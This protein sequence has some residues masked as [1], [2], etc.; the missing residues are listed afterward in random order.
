MLALLAP[1]Q[2]E[3]RV[4]NRLPLLAARDAAVDE[5]VARGLRWLRDQQNRN[6]FW[7]GL[8]GARSRDPYRPSASLDAQIAAGQGHLGVTAL[9]GMAFLA[10]GHLPDRGEHG[11]VV[12]RATNAVLSCIAENGVLTSSG[13]RMYSHAF[14]TLFLAEVYGNESS[15]ELK[16]GL[17]R[18]TNIIVDTQ[19][20]YG[21]WRYQAFSRE[22]DLSVTV[23]QL[24]ALRAARNIGIGIPKQTID[25]AVNYVVEHQIPSGAHQGR[26]YY[27]IHG[28]RRNRKSDHYSI[29]AAAATSL[30]SAGIYE[31]RLLDDVIDFLS[32]EMEHV[33][34]SEPHHYHF[35]YGNYYASQVFYHADGLLRKGCFQRYYDTMRRHL[36]ADQLPDGNWH[37]PHEEGPGDAFA[38]AIACIILQIPKQYLPI[39]QR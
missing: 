33:M 6:G 21:G 16:V 12:K 24:Q 29:Q 18:A 27:N 31:K 37:N 1:A 9:C 35:W 15:E 23:C 20:N 11:H 4:D 25:R 17:E 39:F 28:R 30:L 19:N 38:T 5:S 13:T 8:V 32:D 26:Y 34:R 2:E 36:L 3:R 14:G 7:H 10:G 22:A